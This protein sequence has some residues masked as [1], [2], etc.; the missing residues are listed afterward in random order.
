MDK[1]DHYMIATVIV[2]AI[3]ISITMIFGYSNFAAQEQRTLSAITLLNANGYSVVDAYFDSPRIS[4]V[5][6]SYSEFILM[7]KSLNTTTIYHES[8]D[9][10]VIDNNAA[11]AYK[12]TP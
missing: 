3:V 2:G 9:L 6:H 4:V 8:Q 11:F 7:A 5:T 1:Y 12:Y 10:Y